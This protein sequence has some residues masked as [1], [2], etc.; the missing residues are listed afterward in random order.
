M[1]QS[2]DFEA[3]D[4]RLDRK[5]CV[6]AKHVAVAGHPSDGAMTKISEFALEGYVS[7]ISWKGY[8]R[9]SACL[10]IT[11][12][13]RGWQPSLGTL[14]HFLCYFPFPFS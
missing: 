10:H 14:V 7:L 4:T 5:A 3:E 13:V 1:T 2:K 12:V 11:Q 6:E 8:F 9:L